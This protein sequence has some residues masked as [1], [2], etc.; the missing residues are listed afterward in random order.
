M[1]PY[2]VTRYFNED[3]ASERFLFSVTINQGLDEAMFDP[4]SGY[5]PNKPPGKQTGKH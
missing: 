2:N 4:S 1:T 3:M 5:D